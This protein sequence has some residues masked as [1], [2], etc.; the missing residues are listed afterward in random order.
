MELDDDARAALIER[1]LPF[2]TDF[3]YQQHRKVDPEIVDLE[4]LISV[5]RLALCTAAQQYSA[6]RAVTFQA[7]VNLRI[8]GSLVDFVRREY[9]V[10]GY[11]R[12]RNGVTP[13]P[14]TPA[15]PTWRRE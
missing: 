13:P 7:Y 2:A 1:H 14:P 8:R 5:A 11:R 3:A 6:A 4:D 15:V 9:H 12:R 10:K